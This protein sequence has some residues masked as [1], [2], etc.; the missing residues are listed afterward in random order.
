MRKIIIAICGIIVAGGAMGAENRTYEHPNVISDGIQNAWG[1]SS[2]FAYST[3][4][5]KKISPENFYNDTN[6]TYGHGSNGEGSI[7][8]VIAREIYEH[9]GLFGMTQMQAAWTNRSGTGKPRW[10]D[11]FDQDEYKRQVVCESGWSGTKCEKHEYD[12]SDLDIN[13][14]TKLNNPLDGKYRILSGEQDGRITSEIDV[15][16][17]LDGY[18]G[19]SNNLPDGNFSD[20]KTDEHYSVVLAVIEIKPHALIVGPTKVKA[21]ATTITKAF[22][23]KD[24][25][26]VLCAPGYTENSTHDDCVLSSYCEQVAE[27]CYGENLNS[28]DENKNHEWATKT[29]NEKTCKY[30][31]CKSGYGLKKEGIESKECEKCETTRKQG[32]N[33]NGVCE[34]CTDHDK[35]FNG[36]SCVD[37]RYRLYAKDLLD[38]IQN[39]GKCWMKSSPSEYKD[40][41]LC[42]KG[43][44]W[45][46]TNKQCETKKQST[47]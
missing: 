18:Y 19:S 10:I 47:K 22:S 23:R 16:D 11:F 5:S 33:A 24:S 17:Y 3:D 42:G 34:K 37:Y 15:F 26:K 27:L 2:S 44:Y 38:G 30:I 21:S 31:A 20:S 46:E 8:P 35:M 1:W 45:N 12:C 14:K 4:V 40:C 25:Y 32:V 6:G 7:I 36:E 28:F 13:Y 39:I 29:V 41:V 9:G 43:Q